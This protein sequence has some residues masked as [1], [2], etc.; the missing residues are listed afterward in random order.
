MR[1]YLYRKNSFKIRL[2][3][4]VSPVTSLSTFRAWFAGVGTTA[5]FFI[6]KFAHNANTYNKFKKGSLRC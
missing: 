5:S 6:S 4:G 1:N 2:S 3:T